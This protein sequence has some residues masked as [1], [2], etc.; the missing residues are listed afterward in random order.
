VS[1]CYACYDY[2]SVNLM[3]ISRTLMH[4]MF[5]YVRCFVLQKQRKYG[6]KEKIKKK[7][8]KTKNQKSRRSMKRGKRKRAWELY[9][10]TSVSCFAD[11]NNYTQPSIRS[12]VDPSQIDK[13]GTSRETIG[14]IHTFWVH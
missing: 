14:D 8:K 6:N 11:S 4:C 13:E 5:S 10:S 9:L 1:V 12:Q 7:K 3:V 2:I